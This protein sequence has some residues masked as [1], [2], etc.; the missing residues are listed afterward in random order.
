M[1]ALGGFS[2]QSLVRFI[3]VLHNPRPGVMSIAIDSDLGVG[4]VLHTGESIGSGITSRRRTLLVL[5]R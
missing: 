3:E 5:C 2:V 1:R 4:S